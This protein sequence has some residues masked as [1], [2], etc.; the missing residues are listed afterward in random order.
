[1]LEI[2]NTYRCTYSVSKVML[3]SC[4]LAAACLLSANANVAVAEEGCHTRMSVDHAKSKPKNKVRVSVSPQ[5]PHG[6]DILRSKVENLGTSSIL[7]GSTSFS[8]DRFEDGEWR[9][10]PVTP[11]GFAGVAI[12]MP[13]GLVRE[14]KSLRLPP[15]FPPGHYRFRKAIKFSWRGKTYQV[16]ADFHVVP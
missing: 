16:G 7:F 12:T 10:D 2:M 5:F 15:D 8:I 11:D 14:C 1:M 9:L 3:A 6:G 13:G 4:L